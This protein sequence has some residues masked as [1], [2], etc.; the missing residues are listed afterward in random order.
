MLNMG[1]FDISNL[2]S[3]QYSKERPIYLK[4][5]DDKYEEVYSQLQNFNTETYYD[6]ALRNTETYYDNALHNVK[7]CIKA[8]KR[9]HAKI[10]QRCLVK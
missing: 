9:K 7:N 8:V 4:N 5:H 1:N 6:N 3:P 2:P 10:N